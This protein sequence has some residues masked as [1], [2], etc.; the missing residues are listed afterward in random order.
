M[1][2]NSSTIIHDNFQLINRNLSYLNKS[3]ILKLIQTW[4]EI[5]KDRC[6][7]PKDTIHFIGHLDEYSLSLI[8]AC[9]ESQICFQATDINFEHTLLNNPNLFQKVKAIFGSKQFLKTNNPDILVVEDIFQIY[10]VTEYSPT[11]IILST[12]IINSKTSGT[13]GSPKIIC[14]TSESL[15]SAVNK[16][17]EFYDSKEKILSTTNLNHIGVLAMHTLGP[18]VAGSTLV[19]GNTVEDLFFLKSRNLITT[20]SL[21]ELHIKN[22]LRFSKYANFNIDLSGLKVITGGSLLSSSLV[23]TL[24]DNGVKEILSIYGANEALPPIFVKRI[25]KDTVDDNE[26]NNLGVLVQDCNIVLLDQGYKL[27]GPNTSAFCCDA[28]GFVTIDDNLKLIN[29]NYYF[30]G[31]TQNFEGYHYDDILRLT[32]IFS[33]NLLIMLFRSDFDYGIKDNKIYLLLDQSIMSLKHTIDL[34]KLTEFLSDNNIQIE[35]VDI[36]E[37]PRFVKNGIKGNKIYFL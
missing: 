6:I 32:E 20:I 22:L 25:I 4:K 19:I 23:T 1:I 12:P 36:I 15:L 9:M 30:M 24:F 37:K 29:N 13:T 26:L 27:S 18:V 2:L 8:F 11:D 17:A 33:Q 28:D 5:F 10:N 7:N 3:Q 31:R 34:R 16:S 14:H 35:I 21:F